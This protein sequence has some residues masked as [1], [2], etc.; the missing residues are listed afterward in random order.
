MNFRPDEDVHFV[1]KK[2]QYIKRKKRFRTVVLSLMCIA[3]VAVWVVIILAIKEFSSPY[4]PEETATD[5]AIV[6]TELIALETTAAN[7]S[8]FDGAETVE[9]EISALAVRKGALALVSD[10]LGYVLPESTD[11]LMTVWGNKSATYYVASSSLMLAEDAF[12]AADKMFCDYY[13]ETSNGDYQI[14]MGYSDAETPICC[15]EHGTGYA[16]DVNV[17]ANGISYRLAEAGAVDSIYS[18][19]YDNAAKYG[20]VL[21][22]AAEKSGV[23]GMPHDADHFRYVGLGHSQYMADNNLSLEEYIGELQKH[24]YGDKHIE[25]SYDGVSYE[26]FYVKMPEEAEGVF[27]EIPKDVSYTLSGDNIGG[28]IVTLYK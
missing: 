2:R 15:T 3:I 4:L 6:T 24:R 1:A 25:F 18:W 7:G 12:F 23:T 20:F 5:T 28:V 27:I 13:N 22:Y 10:H 14:T 11:E 19:M 16:F 17:Y 8:Y 9:L 26:V 21:R